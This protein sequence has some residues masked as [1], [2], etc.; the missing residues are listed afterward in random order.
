MLPIG[1]VRNKVLAA[2]RN[3]L[4]TVLLPARNQKD[5]VDVPKKVKT[6]LN[7]VFV[8][9]MDDVL[10]AAL[11]PVDETAKLAKK[12]KKDKKAAAVVKPAK[13]VSDETQPPAPSGV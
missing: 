1:G 4:K 12:D 3:G 10:E 13:K 6:D 9:H 11:L 7:L 8:K 2:H 5:L